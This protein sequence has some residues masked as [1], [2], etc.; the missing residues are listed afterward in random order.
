[1]SDSLSPF[2]RELLTYLQR[3]RQEYLEAV[4]RMDGIIQRFWR[5]HAEEVSWTS[6]TY[7]SVQRTVKG[8]SDSNGN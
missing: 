5:N 8:I 3:R 7:G 6:P 2:D 4:Q 1:M